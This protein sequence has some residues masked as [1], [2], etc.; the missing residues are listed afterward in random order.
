MRKGITFGTFD[1]LHAGH[2]DFLESCKMECDLLIVGLHVDPSVERPEKNK[3]I[4]SVFERYIQLNAVKWVDEI[5]PY[6]TEKDLLNI[7][8]L[9]DVSVR[10]LGSEYHEEPAF[11]A[12]TGKDLCEKLEIELMFVDRSHSY[13]STELRNRVCKA[14]ELNTNQK[15]VKVFFNAMNKNDEIHDGMVMMSNKSELSDE[16]KYNIYK[17]VKDKLEPK[18]SDDVLERLSKDSHRRFDEFSSGTLDVSED[19]VGNLEETINSIVVKTTGAK[20]SSLGSTLPSEEE[21]KNFNIISNYK[22]DRKTNYGSYT[23]D[24]EN[25]YSKNSIQA[26][27]GEKLGSIAKPTA[28]TGKKKVNDNND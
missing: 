9:R 23:K 6:E 3:P 10:F 18:V 25:M 27:F 8:A 13:S 2:V 11:S 14:A 20:A 26:M 12:I 24:L 19:I 4:Q 15:R 22:E 1:L 5:I 21:L 7:L 28:T 17:E 16:E